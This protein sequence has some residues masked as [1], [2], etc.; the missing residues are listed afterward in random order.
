MVVDP[1]HNGGNASHPAE[2]NRPVVAYADGRTKACDTTGTATNDGSLSESA[3]NLAVARQLATDLRVQGFR[4]RLTHTTNSGVGPCIDQRAR[5]GNRLHADAAVSIHAD[6]NI[7]PAARGFDVIRPSPA[8]MVAPKV[9]R[10]SARLALAIRNALLGAGQ[11]PANY[12]GSHGLDERGDLGGL[13]LSTV[14]K[15]FL[16]LGN[17]RSP[18]DAALMESGAWRR[19]VADGLARGVERFLGRGRAR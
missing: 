18:R 14:P 8:N 19:R 10:P 5:I 4:T 12:V 2:I 17:M 13:N 9:A 7:N 11:T 1:G 15:V 3:L 16:E 6:G